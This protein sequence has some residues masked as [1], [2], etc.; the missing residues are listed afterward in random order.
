[1]QNK[2]LTFLAIILQLVV[3]SCNN[4]ITEKP[5]KTLDELIEGENASN[6]EK[7]ISLYTKD[8]ELIPDGGRDIIGIDSIIKNYKNIF[9]KS[10]LNMLAQI[11]ENDV[12]VSGDFAIIYG[13]TFGTVTVLKDNIAY[14]VN[15]RFM[16]VLK[17]V[18]YKWKVY[19]LMWNK[20]K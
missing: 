15:Y 16:M 2:V 5:E 10:K 19:K 13:I 17:K 8:A 12:I 3:V 7:V 9:S 18:D 20:N 14:S 11:H 6:L 1:M 4:S